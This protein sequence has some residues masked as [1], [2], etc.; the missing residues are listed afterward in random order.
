VNCFDGARD[1]SSPTWVFKVNQS[2]TGYFG[3]TIASLSISSNL[4]QP[5]LDGNLTK[6]FSLTI[7]NLQEIPLSF[8]VLIDGP[9]SEIV[10]VGQP[11]GTVS[12]KNSTTVILT[13]ETPELRS[14]RSYLGNITVVSGEEVKKIPINITVKPSPKN[15][16]NVTVRVLTKEV[17]AGKSVDFEITIK[18]MFY[19]GEV[20]SQVRYKIKNPAG[21]VVA[22]DSETV[23]V[24]QNITITKSLAIPKDATDGTYMLE[25][26]ATN[27]DE[28]ASNLSDGITVKT[29]K[30]IMTVLMV[31]M[32]IISFSVIGFIVWK[33]FFSRRKEDFFQP[34]STGYYLPFPS[35]FLLGHV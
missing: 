24:T 9:A 13:V 27:A 19:P 16:L 8:E 4:S 7:D 35:R 15:S 10:S 6:Y 23:K 3:Q 11:A 31:L 2:S 29:N 30:G 22:E 1:S 28:H 14:Y 12:G 32:A 34:P 25:V 17:K 20:S 5:V 21:E 33:L 18:N 26:D